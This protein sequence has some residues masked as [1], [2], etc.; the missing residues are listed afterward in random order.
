MTTFDGKWMEGKG[1]FGGTG[2]VG[3]GLDERIH[4]VQVCT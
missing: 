1:E 2:L 4:G 3:K